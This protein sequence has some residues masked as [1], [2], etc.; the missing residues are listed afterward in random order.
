MSETCYGKTR[1]GA[2]IDYIIAASYLVTA[3]ECCIGGI[4][5]AANGICIYR[6]ACPCY[7][8]YIVA[9]TTHPANVHL[10]GLDVGGGKGVGLGGRG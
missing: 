2:V 1:A 9:I 8:E 10:G 6:T 5:S 4:R 7:Y 3:T